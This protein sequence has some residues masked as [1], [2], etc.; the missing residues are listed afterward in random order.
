MQKNIVNFIPPVTSFWGTPD[1]IKAKYLPISY[2]D[3]APFPRNGYDAFRD[4][5]SKTLP[6]YCN[7]PYQDL[8]RMKGSQDS[9]SK[10][11][12]RKA[13]QGYKIVLLMPARFEAAYF[14]KYIMSNAREIAMVPFRI[15]FKDLKNLSKK[16]GTAPFAC[17]VIY[18]NM[19]SGLKKSKTILVA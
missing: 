18:I 16:K 15:P 19:N 3:V 11:I 4:S 17:V 5:W 12:D 1:I 9:W 2:F 10:L 6:N 13:K 14:N 8:Y 7:C